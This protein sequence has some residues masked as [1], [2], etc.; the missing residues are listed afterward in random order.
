MGPVPGI[1]AGIVIGLLGMV[2]HKPIAVEIAVMAMILNGFNLL[3][4]MPLDGGWILHSLLFSR[5]PILDA[6][7]RVVAAALLL[8][9]FH[10]LHGNPLIILGIVMLV[11]VPVTYQNAKIASDLR[12]EGLSPVSPDDQTVPTTTAVAI[13]ARLRA[14]STRAQKTRFLAQRTL[15]VFEAINGRPPGAATT[16]GLGLVHAV[17]LAAAVAFGVLF[18]VAS[19]PRLARQALAAAQGPRHAVSGDTIN[20]RG[21]VDATDRTPHNILAATFK[22]QSAAREIYSGLAT[23]APADE[24]LELFGESVMLGLPV[25]DDA[26][27]RRWLEWFR[28][29]SA[30]VVV[31]TPQSRLMA[32]F[33][34]TGPDEETARQIVGG[35]TAYVI[36][37]QEFNLIPP[38]RDDSL[39]ADIRA[40]H[41]IARNTYVRLMT[42]D[43]DQPADAEV[44]RLFRDESQARKD[45]D[46]AKIEQIHD[47]IRQRHDQLRDEGLETLLRD[48]SGETDSEMV[49]WYEQVLRQAASGPSTQIANNTSNVWQFWR[50]PEW[51]R[52]AA[53]MG[54]LDL[55]AGELRPVEW[56]GCSS[57]G[58]A[59]RDG[60]EVRLSHLVL[61]DAVAGAPQIVR[62]LES[63]GCRR[64]RYELQIPPRQQIE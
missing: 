7:F 51:A 16:I 22:S 55:V 31:A 19:N 14:S 35:L 62:W 53:H 23:Q 40:Q 17:S 1:G 41:R 52:F 46:Q 11:S 12:R 28:S 25:D 3:P 6:A 13:I 8:G 42:L 45:G 48:T 32:T 58:V 56:T 26:S 30:E 10:F 2:F 9:S 33:T 37:P 38:W 64:I 18:L 60:L 5:H 44:S 63:R 29:R 47:Q 24:T 15:Q 4:I 50:G 59:S 20:L 57:G 27:R 39:P 61:N 34:C 54:Q 49:Q 21:D 43:S 36:A